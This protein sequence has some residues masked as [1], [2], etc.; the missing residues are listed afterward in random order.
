[1]KKMIS[2]LVIATFL[3]I[4]IFTGNSYAATLDTINVQT[5]KTTVRPGED[6]KVNVDFGQALGSYTFD[7]SYDKNLFDYVSADGGTANDTGDKVKVTF[8]DTT[9][10]TS[11]RNNMSVAFRAK[12]DITTSNPTEFLMTAEGLANPDASTRFDNITTPIVKNVTV[13]PEYL[14]YVL[15]LETTGEIVK[16]EEKPMSLIFSSPMGRYY[17]HARLVA[18]ST[19]PAGATVQLLGNDQANL[20][21]DIMQ[22]GW[23][24][25]QGFKIGGRNVLQSLQT[26][27]IFSQ[28]G[29]YTITLKLIDRDN[30]DQVIAQ[31]TFSFT[32][33]EM[34][35]PVLPENTNPETEKIEEVNPEEIPTKLPKTGSNVYIPIL[36]VLM[37]LVS[38]YVYYDKKKD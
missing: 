24:D 9:S 16:E 36:V 19:T 18:E 12:A 38:S 14:D 3:E 4:L 20:E 8:D 13:E 17:E 33:V 27:A 30:S 37:A 22:S 15:K 6:I 10:G 34:P 35:T 7:I 2:I 31:E 11:P 26:R 23:G 1:M 25:A 32:A 21:H 29:D 28:A 5:D